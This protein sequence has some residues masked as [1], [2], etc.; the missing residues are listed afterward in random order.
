MVKFLAAWNLV[1]VFAAGVMQ[2]KMKA[3]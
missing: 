3:E 1:P 2:S